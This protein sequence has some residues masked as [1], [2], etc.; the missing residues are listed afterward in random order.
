MFSARTYLLLMNVVVLCLLFPTVSG[1]YWHKVTELRDTQLE[2][3]LNHFRSAMEAR[4]VSVAQ[5]MSLSIHEAV[6]GFDFSFINT[7]LNQVVAQDSDLTQCMITD[8]EGVI[9]AHND[10]SLIGA[11]GDT[12]VDSQAKA[13]F[14]KQFPKI[15]DAAIGTDV[16]I[17]RSQANVLNV[18]SPV[19]NGNQLWGVL[20]CGYLTD[21]LEQKIQSAKL[22]WKS[23]LVSMR[24]TF[25]TLVFFF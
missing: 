22:H 11:V 24:N 20:R 4:G 5:S 23:E 19:Y 25:I 1:Y 17:I 10:Q 13:L 14:D 8:S 18:V 21:A 2:T 15:Y 6:A 3:T 12:S 16:K 7:L 9:V